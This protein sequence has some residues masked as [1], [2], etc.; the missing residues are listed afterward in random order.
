MANTWYPSPELN[1]FIEALANADVLQDT[2]DVVTLLK[3]PQA[4]DEF[5]DAWK[6]AGFPVDENED[7]WDEF[8]EAVGDSDDDE[9]DDSADS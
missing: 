5:Y 8:I 4:Y 3:K 6:T 7:G 9:D 1:G 2:A